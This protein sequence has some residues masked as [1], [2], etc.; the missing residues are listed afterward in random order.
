V[1]SR[2][3][4]DRTCDLWFWRPALCQLSYAPGF[5]TECSPAPLTAYA[6]RVQRTLLGVL[7]TALALGLALIAVYAAIA[8]G[9]AWVIAV[10]AAAL[11]AWMGDLARRALMRRRT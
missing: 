11:A 5:A 2:G 1:T 7:F 9:G 6:C 10:A 3:D 4:R 8:G